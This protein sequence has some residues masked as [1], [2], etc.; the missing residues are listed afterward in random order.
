MWSCIDLLAA[1]KCLTKSPDEFL[2][3]MKI[4]HLQDSEP[5]KEDGPKKVPVPAS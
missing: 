1:S 3:A 4:E 2:F 5:G